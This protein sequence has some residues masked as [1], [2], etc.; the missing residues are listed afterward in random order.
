MA[1]VACLAL[2]VGFS[3]AQFPPLSSGPIDV[4]A[5]CAKVLAEQSSVY[6]EHGQWKFDLHV[7][8]P[9]SEMDTVDEYDTVIRIEWQQD[10]TITSVEPQGG[11][12]ALDGD[13]KYVNI[14][15]TTQYTG[16]ESFQIQGVRKAGSPEDLLTPTITC[17]GPLDGPPPSPPH[18]P[19][20]DL[21]PQVRNYP[22]G[23]N[24]A[25]GTRVTMKLASWKPY[26]EFTV[27]Y[28]DQASLRVTKPAGLTVMQQPNRIAAEVMRFKFELNDIPSSG[29]SCQGHPACLEFEAR[30][31]VVRHPHIVCITPP[32][33]APPTPPPIQLPWPPP[34]PVPHR[35]PPSP[36]T[37]YASR[38]ELGGEAVAT[39]Q[40]VGSELVHVTLHEWTQGAVVTVTVNGRG[41]EVPHVYN[42]EYLPS[43]TPAA[44][45]DYAFSFKLGTEPFEGPALAFELSAL[46]YEGLVALTCT[47]PEVQQVA[48]PPVPEYYSYESADLYDETNSYGLSNGLEQAANVLPATNQPLVGENAGDSTGHGT[49]VLL[50]AL[51]VLMVAAGVIA[52]WRKSTGRPLLGSALQIKQSSAGTSERAVLSAEDACAEDGTF[53]QLNPAAAAA[54]A[55]FAEPPDEPGSR[56]AAGGRRPA[57]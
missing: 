1:K 28:Y 45:A 27:T 54:A 47:M 14:Q 13:S 22:I 29:E 30:P 53:E 44:T 51:G 10:V 42:A 19:E 11:V 32:P 9:L 39:E 17:T 37:I 5:E 4:G 6:T 56:R 57:V 23:S 31:S 33:P 2:L 43:N 7:Q 48:S 18:P 35:S 50:G 34:P 21:A 26:R 46:R 55:A 25:D 16:H 24:A 40:R 36:A 38:C 3:S 12:M 8:F 15:A 41:L 20:C 52:L 49:P